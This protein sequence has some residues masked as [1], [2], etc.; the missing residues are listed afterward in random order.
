MP[1]AAKRMIASCVASAPMSTPVCRP[2]HITSTRSDNRSSSGISEVTTT[3]ANPL[4]G[5]AEYELIDL[6]FRSD[7]N[8]PR[9]LVEKQD[10]RSGRQPLADGD[11][12]LVAARQR[13]DDLIDPRSN[14]LEVSRPRPWRVRIRERNRV[15]RSATPRRL[16]EAR[17]CLEWLK[18]YASRAPCDP[19]SPA[20]RRGGR[21]RPREWI[22]AGSPSMAI[23]PPRHPRA[24]P[25]ID[26]RI[27]VRPD[28]SSPP[29]PRISPRRTSKLTPL[30]TRRQPR[31]LT[32][33]SVRLRTDRTG[34]PPPAADFRRLSATSRP[35]IAEMMALGERLSIGAVNTR[36]PSRSTVTRLASAT[37]SSKR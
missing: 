31:L 34:A 15:R 13:R 27:S 11:F 22:D 19:R 20:L 37:T 36:W 23:S 3:M 24:T 32:V 14:A 28:P 7:V 4:S 1:G 9:R 35:T 5:Q 17:H 12:L 8:A 18:R 29:M 2:S 21:R 6:L 25:K 16:R 33:S 26:S 10:P 30:S